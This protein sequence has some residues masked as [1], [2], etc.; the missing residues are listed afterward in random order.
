MGEPLYEQVVGP[1]SENKLDIPCR[2]YA[3]VGTHETL[4]A[5]LVRRLL[6]NGAN[7][8]FVNRIAD[9]S[10]KIQDLIENP[11]ESILTAAKQEKAVGLK[12]PAIPLPKNLYGAL[13]QNSSGVDLANDSELLSL[14]KT[15]QGLMSQQWSAQAMGPGLAEI[16]AAAE[17]A[18]INPAVHSDQVGSVKEASAEHVNLALSNAATAQAAWVNTPKNERAACLNRAADLMESRIQELMVLLCR[19]SGKTYANAIAE[20]REAVDFLRYYAAQS[21]NLPANAQI[22]SLGTVLCISPWNFPLAIFSGQISAALVAGNT[23]IAKPAE[24]TPLIA[25]LAIQML[26]EAGVPE[27]VVQLIPGRGETVGAQLSADPRVQG[28]MFTG[29]TEVAKI[30]QKTVAKR[31]GTNGQPIPLIAETGGQ[32]AMIV[33]SSALTEQVILDVELGL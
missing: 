14:D 7:T 22:E 21:T 6:E 18:V 4:L 26:W 15:V 33:D 17:V 9:K 1:K 8:S 31:L 5:Y 19:E 30:L 11:R 23:V 2:I 25:A 20:V 24:Q 12:H 28:I 3:P 27:A 32:N 16:T 13:R 29:S 10:L